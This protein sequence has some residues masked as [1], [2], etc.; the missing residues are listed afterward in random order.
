MDFLLFIL[1]YPLV[2]LISILPLPVLYFFSDIL[3]YPVYYLV[4]YRKEV[5]Y[6]N[7]KLAYPD[8]SVEE[9]KQL[10]KKTFKHFLDS[11]FEIIKTFTISKKELKKRFVFE[12]ID[13]VKDLEKENKGIVLMGSHYGNW[14]WL[15]QLG[16]QTSLYP[17]S[18]YSPIKNKYFERIIKKSRGRVGTNLVR[19]NDTI[20]TISELESKGIKGAYG[21]LSDQ[22][23]QL[24]KTHHWGT[25]LG[26][27]VPVVTGAEFLA[28]KYDFIVMN[29]SVT[30]VKRGYYSAKFNVLTK[31]P[32]DYKNYEITDKYL[33]I[34]TE[35]IN[36][37]PEFYL[38]THKR[39]KFLGKY[40]DW[41]EMQNK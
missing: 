12:N 9:L 32:N 4:G 18:V 41:L 21:L 30:R 39:F 5:I 1:V 10:T 31:Q 25:F 7:L 22:S 29:V 36:K 19:K 20:K 27:F 13:L 14:E 2:W 11:I 16:E 24:H 38:W 3:F 37:A 8:K 26:Q 33:K 6:N 17:I 40:Q 28:K 35:H 34:T 23:P 15:L